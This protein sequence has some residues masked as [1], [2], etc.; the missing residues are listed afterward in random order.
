MMRWISLRTISIFPVHPPPPP[1]PEAIGKDVTS[2][3]LCPNNFEGDLYGLHF[4]EQYPR[5]ITNPIGFQKMRFE[6]Q[7][8][9][10]KTN[11]SHF[12]TKMSGSWQ[13]G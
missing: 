2:L 4:S 1:P 11:G 12:Q 6:K 8:E 3:S 7:C 10:D 5:P 9:E 13:D